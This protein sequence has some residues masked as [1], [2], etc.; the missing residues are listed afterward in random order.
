MKNWSNILNQIA[1]IG[2]FGLSL[3]VPVLMCL[4]VCYVLTV[5][6]GLGDWIYIPGFILGIGS[7]CMTAYKTYQSA[8]GKSKKESD[9]SPTAFNRHY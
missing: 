9:D 5:K 3:V 2:Q 7:S 1:M 6:V 8:I 4:A